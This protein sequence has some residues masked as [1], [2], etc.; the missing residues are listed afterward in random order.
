MLKILSFLSAL[1]ISFSAAAQENKLPTPQTEGGMPFMQAVAA[2]KTTREFASR[3]LPPAK[4]RVNLLPGQ[5]ILR[6]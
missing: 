6:P 5:L 2:R 4:Q 1:L 3:A